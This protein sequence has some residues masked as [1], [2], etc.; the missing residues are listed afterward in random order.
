M[1][2]LGIVI[3]LI[4]ICHDRLLLKADWFN[5][6][7]SIL[8]SWEGWWQRIWRGLRSCKIEYF[9]GELQL[10]WRAIKYLAGIG[11]LFF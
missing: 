9:S 5:D 6:F 3:E 7:R 4:E 2:F 1:Y 10:L 11:Q 8:I